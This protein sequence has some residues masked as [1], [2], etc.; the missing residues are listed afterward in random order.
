MSTRPTFLQTPTVEIDQSRYEELIRHELQYEQ[1][2]ELADGATKVI[3]EA[4][5]LNRAIES[6]KEEKGEN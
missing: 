2:R 1:Y 5:I 6:S 4:N 3:I